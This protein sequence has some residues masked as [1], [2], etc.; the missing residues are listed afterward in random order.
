MP[1]SGPW[2]GFGVGSAPLSPL[3]SRALC[4]PAVSLLV[5][6]TRLAEGAASRGCLSPGCCSF[7]AFCRK[8]LK[9]QTCSILDYLIQQIMQYRNPP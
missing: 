8:G 9:K 4:C 2:D 3:A 1:A 5:L 6:R 7:D